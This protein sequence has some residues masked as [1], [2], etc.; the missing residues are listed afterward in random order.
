MRIDDIAHLPTIIIQATESTEQIPFRV[1]TSSCGDDKRNVRYL[2][3]FK[4]MLGNVF[5]CCCIETIIKNFCKRHDVTKDR[6][7]GDKRFKQDVKFI[8]RI[9]QPAAIYNR[10]E[11]MSSEVTIKPLNGDNSSHTSL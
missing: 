9:V 3:S 11:K 10:I 4:G 5:Q 1:T 6:L 7:H 8:I 2:M